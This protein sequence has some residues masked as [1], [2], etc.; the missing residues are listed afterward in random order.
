VP[1]D[2]ILAKAV[3]NVQEGA[4][5]NDT[6]LAFFTQLRDNG[7]SRNESALAVRA[8]VTAANAATPGQD[9]YTQGEAEA[10]L[11]SCY[12]RPAREPWQQTGDGLTQELADAIKK[13]GASFA[14]DAGGRLYYFGL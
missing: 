3:A 4:G 10:T 14:R 5:R 6:G 2:R 1:V 13:A 9:R 12:S 8:W 11:R 7:Y